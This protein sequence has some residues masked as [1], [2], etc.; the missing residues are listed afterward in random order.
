MLSNPSYCILRN[1]IYWFNFRLPSDKTILRF[2]LGTKDRPKAYALARHIHYK[3]KEVFNYMTLTKQQLIVLA[4]KWANS[5]LESLQVRELE[6]DSK[7]YAD[8][9]MTFSTSVSAALHKARLCYASNYDMESSHVA[10]E[11]TQDLEPLN[12]TDSKFLNTQLNKQKVI[13]LEAMDAKLQEGT[14]LPDE[15]YSLEEQPVVAVP[16]PPVET[17][18]SPKLS[19]V[20]EEYAKEKSSSGDWNRGRTQKEQELCLSVFI[21]LMGD[22]P[23]NAINK[24]TGRNFR[25]KVQKYPL[26]RKKSPLVKDLSIEEL[27]NGDI[28]YK[29]IS[30]KTASK[31]FLNLSSLLKWS[32]I[33]GYIEANPLTGM[34]IKVKVNKKDARKPFDANDLSSLFNSPVFTTSKRLH[35]YYYWLPLI[36]LHT[37]A[38]LEEI[39]QLHLSDISE[40]NG[41]LCFSITDDSEDQQLKNASSV[42]YVPVHSQLVSLGLVRYVTER[43]IEGAILLL[44]AL[45]KYSERYSHNPSKWFGRFKNGLGVTEA[46]KTFHSFRHSVIDKL[47]SFQAPDYAIKEIVGHSDESATHGTYGSR[48]P[49]PLAAVIEQMDWN[50]ALCNVK[51]YYE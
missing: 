20:F 34:S 17:I 5:Y 46:T 13:V 37:G 41:V 11:V 8:N 50:N 26:N 25:T 9:E 22:M 36:A 32:A 14:P 10:H 24:E 31:H 12:A 16:V 39:C 6:L 28:D 27:L 15:L 43:R 7:V 40:V 42:R 33:N 18:L 23:I 48:N 2:S 21:E 49:A 51:P 29:P 3:V 1:S 38:R 19:E 4:K 30:Q 45:V 47:R 44:P 35:D